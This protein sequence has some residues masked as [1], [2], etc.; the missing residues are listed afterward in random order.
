MT[1]H[2]NITWQ[3]LVPRVGNGSSY[4]H[5]LPSLPPICPRWGSGSIMRSNSQ[6]NSPENCRRSILWCF[7]NSSKLYLTVKKDKTKNQIQE[8][9]QNR[10]YNKSK[11]N[12]LTHSLVCEKTTHLH[13]HS[14][15]S[16]NT[17]PIPVNVI[18][19]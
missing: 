10:T 7:F 8:W 15:R 13:S 16:P 5:T 2:L 1:W 4:S 12:Y 18:Q 3:Q 6:R 17:I 11:Y 9:Q 14:V 19:A